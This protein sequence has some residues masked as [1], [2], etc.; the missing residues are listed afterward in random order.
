MS[1]KDA[2]NLGEAW[3]IEH[4]PEDLKGR[5]VQFASYDDEE[6]CRFF[7]PHWSREFKNMVTSGSARIVRK[8]GAKSVYRSVSKSDFVTW[9]GTRP[10]SIE[11]RREFIDKIETVI[12]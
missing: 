10:D 5:Q 11:L 12:G 2:R 9:L 8:R 3:V 1:W 6:T 7:H 4:L